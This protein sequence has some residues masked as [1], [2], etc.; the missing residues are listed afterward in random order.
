MEPETKEELKE[1]LGLRG[2]WPTVDEETGVPQL[3]RVRNQ[4]GLGY[5]HIDTFI[6]KLEE[7]GLTIDTKTLEIT[8]APE[9][10]PAPTPPPPIPPKTE[11]K[12]DASTETKSD[13][14][15]DAAEKPENKPAEAPPK[16]TPK[17]EVPMCT[18]DPGC[19][20]NQAECTCTPPVEVYSR[21]ELKKLSYK[22]L[23]AIAKVTPDVPADKNTKELIKLLTGK[24]K[25]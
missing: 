21:A 8:V 25:L 7:Q 20:K 17:P 3:S 22:E 13:D 10:A 12:T 23:Q 9:E 5:I 16:P 19:G 15:T 11:D 6:E 14:T 2:L 4:P 1:M 24:P 18:N